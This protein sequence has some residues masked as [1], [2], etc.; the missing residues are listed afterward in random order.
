MKNYQ[1]CIFFFFFK[2]EYILT[3]L[4]FLLKCLQVFGKAPANSRTEFPFKSHVNSFLTSDA[5]LYAHW[6]YSLL[7]FSILLGT[8]VRLFSLQSPGSTLELFDFCK[9]VTVLTVYTCK[10]SWC[11]SVISWKT[12]AGRQAIEMQELYR[13]LQNMECH[14][15]GMN[16]YNV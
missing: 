11:T 7:Q 5:Y 14:G 16:T 13:T 8:V 3:T 12:N 9:P 1:R 2:S 15:E 10:E 4:F 6:F